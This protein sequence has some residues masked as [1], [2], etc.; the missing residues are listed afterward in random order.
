MLRWIVES[1]LQLRVVVAAVA[2]LLLVFG[3]VLLDDMRVDAL[4]EFSRPYVEIQ[5]EALGL[6]AQE[7]E[8]MITTPME[9]DMLN[10]TP[11]VD[12]IRSV[13]LPGLSSIVMVF[14]KGTDI[15]K[16]RQ[17]AHERMTEIFALPQVSKPPVMINPLSSTA[18]ILDVGLTSD[19][20]SLIDMS[21]LA[22]WTI[23]PRLMGV[24][25]VANVSIWGERRWQ[26]QV[27]V[28]PNRLRDE[29]VTLLQVIKTAGNSLWASPLSFLEASTPGTGGWIDTPNQRLTI[30]HILPIKTAADLA[31]VTVEGAPS[32]R[33]GDVA[34][35]VE[36]HQP[37]IGDAVVKDAPSLTLVVE[38]FPWANTTD[39]TEDV[40]EALD[41]LRPG[42]AGVEMDST[43][44]RP[45]TFLELALGNFY[46]ALSIGMVLVAVAFFLFLPNWRAALVG[47][48]AVLLSMITAVMVL[49]ARGV[50]A[51]MVILAGLMIALSVVISEAVADADNLVRRLRQAREEANGNG[52]GNGRT[53]ATIVRAV[54]EMRGPAV[55]ATFILVLAAVPVLFLEGMS[56]A[57]FHP[58]ATSFIL[59]LAASMLVA[60]AITPALGLLLLKSASLGGSDSAVAGLA[61]GIHGALFG[62]AG[63]A[64]ALAVGAVVALLVV[65]GICVPLLHQESLLPAFKETD[66]MVRWEGSSSASYP[67]MARI[68]ALASRELRALP[69]V[70]N[71]S[72]EMGRAITSDK[73]ANINAG[74]LRVSID[75]AADYD[76]TVAAVRQVMAGYPGLN[77][78]V[79][80]YL[81]AQVRKE[82]AGNGDSLVVRIYGEDLDMIR[83]KADEVQRVL[84]ST[85][86]IVDPRV[87]YPR[88]MP[89]LEIEV[90]IDKAKRHGLKPGDV[91]RAATTL[92]SG[93]EVGSLFEEQKVFDVIV[94]GTP[95]ARHSITNIHELLI[96]TPAGGHV[97][98][99]EVASVRIV[100]SAT[101]IQRDAVARFI[102]VTA[103]VRNRDLAVA[104]AVQR[105]IQQIQ[106]PL[107]YRAELLGEYAER[108]AAQRRVMAFAIAAAIAIFLVLQAFFRSWPLA[109]AVFLTLP[110]ALVGG[111]VAVVATGGGLLSFGGVAGFLGLLGL[112]VRNVVTL[113]SRYRQLEQQGGGVPPA[114]IV[115]RGTLECSAPILLSAVAT[116]LVFLP[117]ALRGSVA[118]L[119][120]MQPMAVVVLGGLVTT[121]LLAL[122]GTP[123]LYLFFGVSREPELDLAELPAA[124]VTE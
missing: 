58:I 102:D 60:L 39:V 68:T 65:G 2:V 77:P 38:K 14:Q 116:A 47:T 111:V 91:R 28:D 5:T 1:S 49:Y 84:A 56:G 101:E 100:P 48:V 70:R 105:G 22:R 16:A 120:I 95:E 24:P 37:L 55:Y 110:M 33:L 4:P 15:M 114:D 124:A 76:A 104:G 112:A 109:A 27:Q 118:G 7:V 92:V 43:L 108:L 41:K 107:E 36:H 67:A 119:E 97:P 78:E 35:V 26:V 90:D 18:R 82:L 32:K 66:L 45:A 30:R 115:A 89:T 74:E 20:L 88:E 34:K 73:R 79:L 96:D 50:I 31:Q 46:S 10:G 83:Q 23:L 106:F 3:F 117:F 93:L 6:S 62:W 40:E 11:W 8:A 71:V 86:G 123:A 63:R 87:R 25:G 17:V 81:Q 59:A 69:G 54:L 52:N 9:A 80:T 44:F 57:F 113:V 72:G 21:V 12:E 29:K 122:V 61:R 103:N 75:P 94:W 51:N 42:L 64:P 19:K 99:K 53:A 98:L 85:D 121:T 13:S